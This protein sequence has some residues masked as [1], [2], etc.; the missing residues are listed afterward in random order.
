MK[1]KQQGVIQG[2]LILIL[3]CVFLIMGW[4]MY[5][6]WNRV[7]AEKSKVVQM[8]EAKKL[9]ESN[10][11]KARFEIEMHKEIKREM[12]K[13]LLRTVEDKEDYR[14]RYEVAVNR[15]PKPTPKKD[16]AVQLTQDMDR[17][18]QERLQ[19]LWDIYCEQTQGGETCGK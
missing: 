10:L 9:A 7:D 3:L 13:I 16:E 17:Q 12:D 15:V 8:E 5:Y 18:S 11:E 4:G 2:Y 14:R 1:Q 6:L 19:S